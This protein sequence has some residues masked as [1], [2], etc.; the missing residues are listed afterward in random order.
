MRSPAVQYEI[1]LR[2][3]TI[4]FESVFLT[5]HPPLMLKV[6][7]LLVDAGGNRNPICAGADASSVAS[8]V[9]FSV[10]Q[11]FTTGGDRC[12]RLV[13][14]IDTALADTPNSKQTHKES[15]N[16][17]IELNPWDGAGQ[18]LPQILTNSTSWCDARNNGT[19]NA[20]KPGRAVYRELG[21]FPLCPYRQS[22]ELGAWTAEVPMGGIGFVLQT[23]ILGPEE[24]LRG[25]TWDDGACLQESFRVTLLE[26]HDANHRGHG[27]DRNVDISF[28]D[29]ASL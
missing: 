27:L 29:N 13:P 28:S 21:V 2:E 23:P 26:S 25:L 1:W 16:Y 5:D 18:A 20:A 24:D 11:P 7:C 9:G 4:S 15:S 8:I 17:G 14:T 19:L 10:L 6:S 22:T 12:S 3:P